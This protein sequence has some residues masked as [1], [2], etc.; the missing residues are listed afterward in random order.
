M[1]NSNGVILVSPE[2]LTELITDA[3]KKTK[4]Q[5][6]LKNV[7]R[8]YLFLDEVINYYYAHPAT[9]KPM[10]SKSTFQSWVSDGFVTKHYVGNVPVYYVSELDELPKREKFNQ[11]KVA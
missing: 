11:L 8:D 3:I 4:T 10:V 6:F 5:E 1:I 7:N 9:G 2:Q